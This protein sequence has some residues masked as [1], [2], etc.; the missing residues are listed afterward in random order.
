MYPHW[1]LMTPLVQVAS[2]F[3]RRSPF[4]L[5]P[6]GSWKG[7]TANSQIATAGEL[8]QFDWWSKGVRK[9]FFTHQKGTSSACPPGASASQALLHCPRLNKLSFMVVLNSSPSFHGIKKKRKEIIKNI[10]WIFADCLLYWQ[11]SLVI[12][13]FWFCPLQTG[14]VHLS[15]PHTT[16]VVVLELQWSMETVGQGLEG[17]IISSAGIIQTWFSLYLLSLVLLLAQRAASKGQ[18]LWVRNPHLTLVPGLP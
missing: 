12:S 13:W 3:R 18:T 10:A 16:P 6:N 1:R 17:E 2:S 15:T 7:S 9:S 4:I 14:A 11:P 5:L 8:E